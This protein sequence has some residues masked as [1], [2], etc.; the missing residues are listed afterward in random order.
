MM[1]VAADE[2]MHGADL[3]NW[4]PTAPE[5]GGQLARR[6]GERRVV[7]PLQESPVPP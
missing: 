3:E 5:L 6:M 4:L 7:K 2:L 1:H